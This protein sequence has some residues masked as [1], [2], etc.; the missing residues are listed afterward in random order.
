[1]TQTTLAAVTVI[2]TLFATEATGQFPLEAIEGAQVRVQTVGAGGRWVK[3][4]LVALDSSVL[5]LRAPRGSRTVLLDRAHVSRI[6]VSVG[7]GTG[8]AA[9]IGALVGLFVA[10]VYTL[11]NLGAQGEALCSGS[12]CAE[13]F[14][15]LGPSA[16]VIGAG[17]GAGV[18][19]ER[20]RPVSMSTAT[21]SPSAAK[22][23]FGANVRTVA[24]GGI[25]VALS[26]RF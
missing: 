24:G 19:P 13:L 3:G 25:S 6:E 2:V 12:G 26:C 21:T 22:G 17:V 11:G 14:L 18:A 7:R 16:A 23:R 1:M 8:Q 4:R 15:L 5:T 20:W 9:A 10:G